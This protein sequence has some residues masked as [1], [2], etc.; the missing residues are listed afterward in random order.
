MAICGIVNDRKGVPANAAELQAMLASMKLTSEDSC[1]RSC[2]SRASFGAISSTGTMSLWYSD[3]I[4]VA[5]DADLFNQKELETSLA[6][7]NA[8]GNAAALLAALY[9]RDG[10]AFLQHLRGVFALAIWNDKS[11]TL[12]LAVDRF[13]V[14]TLC[15][16][17]SSSDIVFA[18]QP[19][20]LLA[21]GRLAKKV[22]LQAV[23]N[24][25]NFTIVPAPQCVFEG[26]NKLSPGTYLLS[27]ESGICT[28]PYWEMQYPEN[29]HAS[30]SHLTEEL[31]TRME[32]AVSSASAGIP[33]PQLGC[34]LSGGTDSSSILGLLTRARNTPANAFSI[35]FREG[36]FNELEYAHMAARWF[37]AR[38]FELMLGPEETYQAIP[39]LVEAF[40][41]PFGNAS[42]FPSYFCAE[43]ARREGIQ[44]M[45]AGDGGDELFGGNERYRTH[46]IFDVYQKVPYLLRRR[47]IEPL[48]F[49][50]PISA[51][52]LQKLQ[53]YV[54]RS[55][56]PNP[57]RYLAWSPL[58]RFPAHQVLGPAMPSRNGNGDLLAVAR[59]HYHSAPAASELNRLL[60]VDV[61]MTLGDNDLPKVARTAEVAGL[62][63]R[64][65]YLDHSLA[66][67]S[68]RLPV[69]LK[70]RGLEKRYLFKRATKNLLPRAILQKKKHG[71]GL[72]IGFWLKSDRK[73]RGFA[74]DI[75]LDPRTY[76]RGYFRRQFV[77]DVF[78]LMDSDNTPYYGDL[79]WP[80]LMLEL[81]H[82][83]HV[84][85]GTA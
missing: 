49:G 54:R 4:L 19:R 80:F 44:V 57:E 9:L 13:G 66:E 65:P 71:F 79:L 34:F 45:L 74:E 42:A 67:F 40:D 72:P 14:K 10:V 84:D 33:S 62:N 63:V 23:V 28:V 85:G 77:E 17:G 59:R 56:T 82:R 15:Y 51:S 47:L 53:R 2:L 22:D 83:R 3:S 75:L 12:L 48:L 38:H 41:E 73:L 70:V 39:K 6:S 16:A 76:Q 24:Y 8:L 50:M 64:F 1:A 11:E 5:C 18:S 55:N 61:K 20:G 35:G 21:S 27:K 25:L 78:A 32:E 31:L 52:P 36:R 7:T 68:G 30:T 81:W 60:Y 37:G 26:I 46:Q 58:Q 69:H 43:L 29:T